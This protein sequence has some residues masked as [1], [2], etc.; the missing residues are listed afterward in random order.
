VTEI[1]L[2]DKNAALEKLGK[3]LGMFIADK[4]HDDDKRSGAL[5]DLTDDELWERLVAKRAAMAR[6]VTRTLE[7]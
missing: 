5:T 4:T 2:W 3:H 1:K 7:G 6:N